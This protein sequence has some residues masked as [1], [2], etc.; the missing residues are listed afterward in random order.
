ME[1]KR[2][3]ILG[4]THGSSIVDVTKITDADIEKAIAVNDLDEALRIIQKAIG[5]DDGGVAGIHFSNVPDG[6]WE[7]L[8]PKQRK[9]FVEYYLRTEKMYAEL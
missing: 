3:K 4:L 2:V 1:N 7:G 8:N 5:Q 6:T 9:G